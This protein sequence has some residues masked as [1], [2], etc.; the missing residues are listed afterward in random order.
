MKKL[1]F[2]CLVSLICAGYGSAQACPSGVSFHRQ[3][4]FV[5]HN[6]NVIVRQEIV[7]FTNPNFVELRPVKFQNIVLREVIPVQFV[8]VDHGH[9]HNVRQRQ[10]RVN[11]QRQ[12]VNVHAQ[13]LRS[14]V[15]V[16]VGNNFQRSR[17]VEVNVNSNRRGLGSGTFLQIMA[18][19]RANRRDFLR[20]ALGGGRN[21]QVRRSFERIVN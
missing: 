11:V 19:R 3:R 7:A 18:E 16:N 17:R 4:N 5:N 10:V 21:V 8:N 2:L 1:V 20:S 9:A 14:R 15:N 12:R 13:N 6:Q